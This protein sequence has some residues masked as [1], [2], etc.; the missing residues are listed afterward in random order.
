MRRSRRARIVATLGPASRAPAMVRTLA[1]TGVDVFRLNFS[2]GA[3]DDH[4]AAMDA[5]RAAEQALGR[6]L[7][8][9]ADL[10][11]PK[12][13]VGVFADGRETLR[14]GDAFRFDMDPKAGDA[15]RA[16]LPHPEIFAALRPDTTLLVDDGRLRFRILECSAEHAL[17]RVEVG[18]PI[19]DRKGVNAPD[20]VLPLPALTE[21][22]H[23]DLDVA[24]ALGADWIAQSFVQGPED[25]AS[26]CKLV[27]GRAGVLAKLEKPSA[28]QPQTLEAILDYVDGV[29]V[30]RGDLGVEL[31]PEDVPVLQK[32]IV[33]AAR[34]RGK[35][36]IVATQMLDSMVASPT[37]TRAEAS[38]VATAVYDGADAVMLSA[39]SAV[40][41]YPRETVAMMDRII[42]RVEQA[43][44]YETIMNADRP[45]PEATGPDALVAAARLV[46]HTIGAAALVTYTSTGR[47]ALR[48]ARERPEAPILAI[49]PSR[50][51][52]RRLA[53][54]WGVHA[55]VTEDAKDVEDMVARACTLAQ[56]EGFAQQGQRIAIVAGMPFGRSGGTNLL[57]LAYVT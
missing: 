4:A 26:L 56:S 47:S 42:S 29:M 23:R 3:A 28:V 14:E 57:R 32:H 50:E 33:R 52:A 24:L 39:E 20:V 5:V 17:T 31:P 21:K 49:T 1:E 35:P 11:G 27:Q 38:D 45:D 44:N 16:P 13:R 6:P 54:C 40:G 43:G 22:D 30:A 2:H 7:A 12:L 51:A 8:A 55:V 53:L 19:S 36:V 9:L 25:V 37:P 10:Q 41:Q 15:G 46:V 34:A 48:A 18:G